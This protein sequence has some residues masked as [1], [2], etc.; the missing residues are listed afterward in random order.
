M[1]W[2]IIN[3]GD[4]GVESMSRYYTGIS[5]EQWPMRRYGIMAI[6]H[7]IIAVGIGA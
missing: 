2:D 7:A 4:R 1:E 6:W 3:E 5:T